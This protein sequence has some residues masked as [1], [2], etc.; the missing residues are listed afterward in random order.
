MAQRLEVHLQPIVDLQTGGRVFAHESLCRLRT[1]QGELLSGADTF[2][3]AHYLGRSEVLDMALQQRALQRKAQDI[4][5]GVPLFL[6]VMPSTLLQPQWPDQLMQ[7]L[8]QWH[9]DPRE[10]VIEVVESEQVNPQELALRCDLLRS[11]GLRIALDDMG[12]GFNCLTVLGAVRADFIK[13][14]RE[15]VHEARGSR[16]RSVL[17]EALVS[18]AERLGATVIA[19]G[20]ERPQDVALCRTLG[21]GLV[22]GFLLARPA[23]APKE[24]T[25]FAVASDGAGIPSHDN[26]FCIDDVIDPG[27]VFD[28]QT[29]VEQV[30]Q[31]FRDAPE[32]PWCMLTDAG[33][34]VGIAMRGKVLSRATRR[35]LQ[36]CQPLQRVLAHDAGLTVLARSLYLDRAVSTPWAV[37]DSQGAYMGTL[38]P[39]MLVAHLLTRQTHG[40]SLHPLSQLPTGPSLRHAI[41]MRIARK[42]GELALVYID[43]DHFKSFNDR[44][45]F[46]RG[47]AMIR[48]LAEILRHVFAANS[49]CMLGHIGGDDF[50]VLLDQPSVQLLE[51]LRRAMAQF[52]ALARHLYDQEDLERGFFT[53]E[54]GEHHPVASLSV[55]WVNGS[56]GMPS[57]SVSAAE[58]AARL[59]KLGKSAGGN[60]IVMEAEQPE[61]MPLEIANGWLPAWEEHVLDI[62]HHVLQQPRGRDVHALDHVFKAY[63]FFE[64]LFELD[65]QGIQRHGNWINPAMYGRIRTGGAGVD[66]S[67]QPYFTHVQANA[68]P[69]I[70]AIYLS[71]ASED[72][73]LTIAVPQ[74]DQAQHLQAILV[75]DLNLAAMAA[76]LDARVDASTPLLPVQT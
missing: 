73:C 42:H 30:R 56:T 50:I 35:L 1:P 63:P 26:F 75:G 25:V 17:L 23:Y 27:L 74:Y 59:K 49:G 72:F 57:D 41:E 2:A 10:L 68:K 65:G 31:A 3:L 58:R 11:R 18:M 32:L 6:N 12:S 21:I 8:Q 47:D 67:A 33:R 38:E 60:V 5:A 51:T 46:V 13:L 37:V 22:Q 62:L 4:E 15:L 52:R 69:F 54:D 61:V 44:Y 7:W 20:L 40:P 14:D 64:V 39:M 36:V 71:T 48:T 28:V 66:R 9:I 70:S 34:P 53:T 76:L 24:G 45:G 16:V 19:E 43:L 29:P 55:A